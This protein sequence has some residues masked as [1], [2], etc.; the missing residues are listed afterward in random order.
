MHGSD[1]DNMVYSILR[2]ECYRKI[3]IKRREKMRKIKN[4]FLKLLVFYYLCCHGGCNGD[5]ARQ[6][7]SEGKHTGRHDF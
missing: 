2:E 5:H 6:Q 7:Q 1:R 4:F 3:T